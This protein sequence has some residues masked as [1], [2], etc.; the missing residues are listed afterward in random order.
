MDWHQDDRARP[1]VRQYQVA[2]DSVLRDHP[3]FEDCA[4][5]CCHCGI[6]FLTHPRN[7]RRIDLRCP[8]GC[9]QH[10]RRQQSKRRSTAYYQTEKGKA[11]K[12]EL[13]QRRSMP[14][15]LD[16][17]STEK[18]EPRHGASPEQ[19]DKAS[20]DD[21]GNITSVPLN[22]ALDVT[23]EMQLGGVLLREEDVVHSSLLPYLCGVASLLEG[24]TIGRNELVTALLKRMRQRRIG[25]RPHREYVRSYLNQHPP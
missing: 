7:A 4:V 13:N 8:F 24:R 9:R 1:L 17:C 6:R 14:C 16:E 15:Q 3:H 2:L 12:S 23:L 18:H 20:V 25:Q 21:S 11:L 5:T 19:P 10:H 22:A